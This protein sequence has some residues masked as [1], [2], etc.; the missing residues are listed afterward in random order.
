VYNKDTNSIA[1]ND[2]GYKIFLCTEGTEQ[3]VSPELQ[4]FLDFVAGRS[5]GEEDSNL[6][7]RLK[8]EVLKARDHEEWRVEYMTLLMRDKEKIEEG[9]KEERLKAINR[10]LA[11][12]CD[13]AFILSLDYSEEE[14]EQAEQSMLVK[15]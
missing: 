10:M 7:K 3:D 2:G 6:V 4:S 11:K 5:T 8:E 14:Y 9:R 12:G 15:A 13:K 1:L